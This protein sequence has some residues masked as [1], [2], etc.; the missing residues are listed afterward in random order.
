M[1]SVRVGGGAVAKRGIE[2]PY[3]TR[4]ISA[5]TTATLTPNVDNYDMFVITAQA[6]ALTIANPTG[7]PVNGNGFVIRIKD[8]GTARAITY[9]NKFRAVGATLPSTT[10]LSKQMYI[11]ALWNSTD[12]K[13]DVIGVSQEI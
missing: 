8:N 2:N 3:V 9:G 6:S 11:A 5:A 1:T 10:V 12:S 13:W 7:T 4:T